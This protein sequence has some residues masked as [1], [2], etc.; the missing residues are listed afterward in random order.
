MQK[1]DWYTDEQRFEAVSE[2]KSG[3]HSTMAG[4]AK[5]MGIKNAS[6]ISI[7]VKAV[8]LWGE[9]AFKQPGWT[10]KARKALKQAP[11][12]TRAHGPTTP[13]PAEKRLLAL[14]RARE[15]GV[16]KA[17]L[18]FGISESAVY[19]WQA[20]YEKEGEKGLVTRRAGPVKAVAL[21]YSS[22][23]EKAD[24]I[25]AYCRGEKIQ[26]CKMFE[27][28]WVTLTVEPAW[29]FMNYKYRVAPKEPRKLYVRFTPRGTPHATL[30][31]V[32]GAVIFIETPAK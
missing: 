24:L 23:K 9:E 27:N 11:A 32:K 14:V 16:P 12:N 26:S 18:E 15:I 8:E 3:R 25:L 19:R 31:P 7:W 21:P 6:T 4:L 30:Y 29:D 2:W 10:D 28:E 20:R 22:S 17:A 1:R 13:V 5:A